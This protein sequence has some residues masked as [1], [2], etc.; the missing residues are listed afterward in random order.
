MSSSFGDNYQFLPIEKLK[1][2]LFNCF[3]LIMNVYPF[4]MWNKGANMDRY[5]KGIQYQ[6]S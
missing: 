1:S 6:S 2:L 5:S 3:S 4:F